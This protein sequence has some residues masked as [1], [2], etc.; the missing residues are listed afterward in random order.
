MNRRIFLTRLAGCVL[1]L[2]APVRTLSEW[3]SSVAFRS[4]G[5]SLGLSTAN[6]VEI[7]RDVYASEKIVFGLARNRYVEP[8]QAKDE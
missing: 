5:S 4:A 8:A 1:V 7:F 2:T 3:H 6:V